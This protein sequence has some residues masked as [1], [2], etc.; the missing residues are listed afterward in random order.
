VRPRLC[1]RKNIRTLSGLVYMTSRS[2]TSKG[3]RSTPNWP[4]AY[5][6]G[7]NLL[8]LRVIN[9]RVLRNGA[10]YALYVQPG[11]LC[12][13]ELI[14]KVMHHDGTQSRLV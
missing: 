13:C 12:C 1:F 10:V 11:G 7:I 3:A 14:S 2:V 6:R 8:G 9:E 4:N 5:V